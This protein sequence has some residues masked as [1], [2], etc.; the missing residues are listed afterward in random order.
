[1][2]ARKYADA[3]QLYGAALSAD[4]AS[5]AAMAGLVRTTLA[6]G[7]MPEALAMAIKY[8]AAHPNDPNLLDALG[9]VR[10]RRGETDEAAIAFNRSIKLDPCNGVTHYDMARFLNFLALYRSAQVNLDLAYADSP[11]NP[12]I[13]GLWKA[14]HAIPPTPEQRLERLKRQLERPSLT[15]ERKAAIQTAINAVETGEKGGCELV[16]PVAEVKLS[17]APIPDGVGMEN[18]SEAGLDIQINGKRRRLE[19]DTGASGLIVSSPVA[20]RAGLVPELQVKATGVGDSGPANAYVTHVDDI[21]IG[22]MEFTN[23]IV[24][25]LQGSSA[26]DQMPDVDGLI[27][28]DVFKNYLVTLDYPGREI[29]LGPLPKRPDDSGTTAT[30]L[31][32]S[33]DDVALVSMADRAKDRYIAPEMKD[34]TPVFRS[35]HMLIFPTLIGKAPTKLFLMDTG[36]GL[37]LISPPAAREVTLLSGFTNQK[38]SGVSGQVQT[39]LIADKVNVTLGH[40]T[41]E[42]RGMSSIDTSGLSRSA[43]ADIS[44][45][46]GFPLLRELVISIDYRDSLVHLSYDPRKG[47]HA[48]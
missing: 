9:E 15:D 19:I 12:E 21:K 22:P 5:I 39:V 13:Q 33:D 1:L 16:K 35:G 8:D 27:G 37:N 30:S 11:E 42:V 41:Q 46:I 23:C 18:I 26:L 31:A 44:G 32:T 6:E 38:I 47:Y 40:V 43:G 3:E 10:Y 29:R 48:H 2:L 4:P 45:I 7:K 28:P 36:S 17:M 25:V 34:W 24:Q 20:K 14:T